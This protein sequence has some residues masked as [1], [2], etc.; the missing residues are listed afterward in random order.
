MRTLVWLVL[1]AL[2]VFIWVV[3]IL[4]RWR[5]RHL[6]QTRL[7]H[8]YFASEKSCAPPHTGGTR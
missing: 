5:N 7:P 1:A 4:P 8:G 3:D 6:Q 2:S